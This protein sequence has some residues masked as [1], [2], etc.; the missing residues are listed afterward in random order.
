LRWPWQIVMYGHWLGKTMT[1]QWMT[2]GTKYVQ[3]P[4]LWKP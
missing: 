1:N 3:S 4:F 2:R